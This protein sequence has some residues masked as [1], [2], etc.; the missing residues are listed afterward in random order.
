MLSNSRFQHSRNYL[1]SHFGCISKSTI[2]TSKAWWRIPVVPTVWRPRKQDHHGLKAILG[3]KV[4][5]SLGYLVRLC[6]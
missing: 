1:L 3:Y 6:L 4:N 5:S 2:A